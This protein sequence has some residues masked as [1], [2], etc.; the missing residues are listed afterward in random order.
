LVTEVGIVA[1]LLLTAWVLVAMLQQRS[2]EGGARQGSV[3]VE[4]ALPPEIVQPASTDITVF[5]FEADSLRIH[6]RTPEKSSP[7]GLLAT[8]GGVVVLFSFV[9]L[10]LWNIRQILASLVAQQPLT[11]ANAQRFRMISLLMLGWVFLDALR[12]NIEYLRLEPMFQIVPPRGFWSLFVAHADWPIVFT[13]L[14]VLLMA[15]ILKLGA[16]SRADSEAVI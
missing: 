2:I 10:I 13:A 6:Y 4:F 15:Q 12:Q 14:L 11:L 3:S 5:N 8:A 16:E 9:P 7:L 1:W